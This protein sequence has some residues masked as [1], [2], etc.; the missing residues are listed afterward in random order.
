[1]EFPD[2]FLC[3]Q[4]MSNADLLGNTPCENGAV[5]ALLGA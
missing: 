4:Q 5:G 3:A 1:M 2:D